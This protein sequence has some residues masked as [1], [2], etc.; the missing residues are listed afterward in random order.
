MKA[1][2]LYE[3]IVVAV[4]G[5]VTKESDVIDIEASS[6]GKFLSLSNI[7]FSF[8]NTNDIISKIKKIYIKLK[9]FCSLFCQE[10]F[11]FSNFLRQKNHK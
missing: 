2:E 4:D 3:F 7:N 5:N 10:L 8:H 6:T 11:S 9:L 1:E